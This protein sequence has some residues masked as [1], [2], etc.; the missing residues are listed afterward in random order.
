MKNTL[1][2]WATYINGD[3]QEFS[4]AGS[5][6]QCIREELPYRATSG[7]RF[8]TLTDEPAVR[9]AVSDIIYD[10]YGMENPNQ[11]EDYKTASELK[12]MMGGM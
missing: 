9:K 5:Y 12:M 8:E 2:G 10:F 11:L 1:V 7:F 3:V 6:I 4:D